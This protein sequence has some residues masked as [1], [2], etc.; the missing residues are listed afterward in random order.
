[1]ML[2]Q[3]LSSPTSRTRRLFWTPAG[4]P[5][6]NLPTRE[7]L[8]TGLERKY[9]QFRPRKHFRDHRLRTRFDLPTEKATIIG[10]HTDNITSILHSSHH[11]SQT[12][13]T[14]SMD[15]TI[16]LWDPRKPT[17]NPVAYPLPERVY[18]MDSGGDKLVVCLAGR[19][20]NIYDLRMMS[21]TEK[22]PTAPLQSKESSLRYMT[23][24]VAC[25]TDGQG[26][27]CTAQPRVFGRR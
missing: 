4:V 26:D 3:T 23:K 22:E 14:G 15:Q 19:L 11:S 18:A 24:T 17:S 8:T 10:G 1:M 12:V 16:R 2:L 9:H 25:M 7:D 20:V 6:T 21:T 5:T 27:S 13:I